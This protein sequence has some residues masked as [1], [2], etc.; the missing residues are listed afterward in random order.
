MRRAVFEWQVADVIE[1]LNTPAVRRR[2]TELSWIALI[3]GT[4][5]TALAAYG[6][7]SR[8]VLNPDPFVFGIA[9][10]RLLAGQRLYVDF[11]EAKP[12]LATLFYAIPGAVWP[13]SYLAVCWSLAALLLLQ[14]LFWLWWFRPRLATAAACLWFVVLYPASFGPFGWLSTEHMA[15]LFITAVLLVSVATF[16]D[17]RL[18][19]WRYVLAGAATAAAFHCRQNAVL[20][21]LVPLAVISLAEQPLRAKLRAVAWLGCGG[22]TAWVAIFG[23]ACIVS[24]P[25]SYFFQVFVFPR[26][27][28]QVGG[29]AER[30]CLVA[31]MGDNSLPAL[32]GVAVGLGL[33]GPCRRLVLIAIPVALLMC[34]APPRSHYNYWVLLFPFLT[35][36][37]LVGLPRD[38]PRTPH[39][40]LVALAVFSVSVF[41]GLLET[42]PIARS[43]SET[44]PMAEVA[45]W[46][47]DHASPGDTLYVFAPGG[48]EYVLFRSRLLPANKYTISWEIDAN[49]GMMADSFDDI[50]HSYLRHPP[51]VFVIHE[52]KLTETNE[53]RSQH[54]Q[55]ILRSTRI[56]VELLKTHRYDHVQELNGFHIHVLRGAADDRED[57]AA[58]SQPPHREVQRA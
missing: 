19:W 35:M 11:F 34:L 18:V 2:L 47:D 5:V 43:P 56:A 27:F 38:H 39:L 8:K 45:T 26:R 33:I 31:T 37:L 28:A 52:S 21:A 10:K 24:D 25:Q 29:A 20:C 48:S 58:S 12:P 7:L 40:E 4:A 44:A 53:A 9:A 15:N 57:N 23:V 50:L 49:N 1:S 42:I 22:V 17:H 32:L 6:S 41:A 46:I 51:T 55:E 16:R 54:P 14:G 36:S 13:R 30:F 3:V